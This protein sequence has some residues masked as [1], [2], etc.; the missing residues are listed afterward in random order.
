MITDISGR[1]HDVNLLTDSGTVLGFNA[2]R[3][4]LVNPNYLD[5]LLPL[6]TYEPLNYN[7]NNCDAVYCELIQQIRQYDIELVSI[8]CD[9]CPAQINGVAQ[10]L[11]HHPGLALLHI[12][13][14]NHLMNLVFTEVLS[15]E[16]ISERISLLNEFT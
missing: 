16:I 7:S 1:I 6:D 3:A 4:I 11:V 9:N 13:C 5:V 14:L 15:T 12:P 8:I 10:A 2:F